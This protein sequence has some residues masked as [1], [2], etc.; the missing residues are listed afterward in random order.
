[1]EVKEGIQSP[2]PGVIDGCEPLHGCR[3]SNQVLF[4][5]SQVFLTT[6]LSLQPSKVFF[7]RFFWSYVY[8]YVYMCM[9]MRTCVWM[10]MGAKNGA[11]VTL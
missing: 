9:G 4:K 5:G 11:G 10:P 1:M 8:G 6:K 2:G 3:E 7:N